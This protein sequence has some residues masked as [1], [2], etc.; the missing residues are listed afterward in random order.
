MF[1]DDSVVGVLVG[2]SA[3][4]V[5]VVVVVAFISGTCFAIRPK[6]EFRKI[7]KAKKKRDEARVEQ[8]SKEQSTCA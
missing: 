4:I 8:E 7:K 3:L 5:F 6:A 1:Q 2:L